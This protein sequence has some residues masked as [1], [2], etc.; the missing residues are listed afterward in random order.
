[1]GRTTAKTTLVRQKLD[2]WIGA[3]FDRN[4]ALIWTSNFCRVGVHCN[5]FLVLLGSFSNVGGENVTIKM[6]SRFFQT[7]LRLFHSPLNVKCGW[8]L[9]ELNSWRPHPSL[10]RERKIGRRVFTSSI[11]RPIRK[12]HVLVVQWRQ[13]NVPKSVMYVQ[14]CCFSY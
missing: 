2:V 10:E 13:R 7:S 8:N 14:S 9:M 4:T 6:N 3:K 11:E 12:F 5:F 1:M